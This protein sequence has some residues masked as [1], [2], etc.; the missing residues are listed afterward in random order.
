MGIAET[1]PIMGLPI[2]NVVLIVEHIQSYS[3]ILKANC[4]CQIPSSLPL[5]LRLLFQKR[6]KV[7]PL[8]AILGPITLQDVPHSQPIFSIP[9]I[10][11]LFP[12]FLIIPPSVYSPNFFPFSLSI[13]STP[14]KCLYF[15][16]VLTFHYPTKIERG[17]EKI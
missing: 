17:R 12:M 13:F 4:N 14:C 3:K 6:E 15:L 11:N 2:L 5:L 10:S 1:F 9:L 16:N 8:S 7:S